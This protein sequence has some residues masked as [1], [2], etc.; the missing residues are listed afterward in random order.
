MV[1]KYIRQKR[2][3]ISIIWYQKNLSKMVCR[4][5]YVE[6]FG[7]VFIINN[8]NN[9]KQFWNLLIV[10]VL[11]YWYYIGKRPFDGKRKICY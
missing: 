2:V 3:A 6:R 4:F 11:Q 5:K 10:I 9:D 7:L 1:S 8:N